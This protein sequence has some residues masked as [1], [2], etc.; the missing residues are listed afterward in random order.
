LWL[1][2]CKP[3]QQHRHFLERESKIETKRQIDL[4]K[5]DN[6]LQRAPQNTTASQN[7]EFWSP[8]P[9][10][11]SPKHSDKKGLGNIKEETVEDCKSQR[12]WEFAVKLCL[13]AV[14]E[15]ILI[16]SHQQDCPNMRWTK[17]TMDMLKP[18]EE[19]PGGPSSTQRT[20]C[21]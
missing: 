14:S 10:D 3:C 17:T 16:K 6:L 8:V 5:Y 9:N 1:L 13:L 21:N 2:N 4:K 12:I 11:T 20:A 19:S 18:T 7:A 15:S